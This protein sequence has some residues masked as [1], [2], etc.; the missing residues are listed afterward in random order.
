MW[1]KSRPRL[2]L[3]PHTHP[4]TQSIKAFAVEDILEEH[5]PGRRGQHDNSQSLPNQF[6]RLHLPPIRP[7]EEISSVIP[8]EH[9]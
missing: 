3:K 9:L 4:N 1:M 8:Q 2:L 6:C 5:F 7:L